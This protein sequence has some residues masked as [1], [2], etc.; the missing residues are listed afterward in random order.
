M[1]LLRNDFDHIRMRVAPCSKY[2]PNRYENKTLLPPCWKD[3]HGLPSYTHT[4]STLIQNAKYTATGFY[5][6]I[7]TF[8]TF[9]IGM[10]RSHYKAKGKRILSLH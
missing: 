3:H 4:N 5:T 1:Y 6:P 2:E 8:L 9:E 7:N 10:A